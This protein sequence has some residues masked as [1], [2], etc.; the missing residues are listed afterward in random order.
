M[1]TAGVAG[2]CEDEGIDDE[3]DGGIVCERA[4]GV[5]ESLLAA[6]LE[7]PSNAE[8]CDERDTNFLYSYLSASALDER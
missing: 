5:D 2:S 7:G 6:D 8:T 3:L 1:G 4:G